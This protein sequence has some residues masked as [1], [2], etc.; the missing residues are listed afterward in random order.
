M[1]RRTL[2]TIAGLLL[3]MVVLAFPVHVTCGA[4]G[5]ACAVPPV[6]PSTR[7][8]YYYEVEPAGIMLLEMITG[9]SIR[10]Y[11]QSGQE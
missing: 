10:V 9:T 7:P 1:R 3:M 4:P 8:S 6:P 5:A 11:Y 2:V